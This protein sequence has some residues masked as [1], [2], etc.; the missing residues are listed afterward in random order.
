MGS[1]QA[2]KR[3]REII[4]LKKAA[5][6]FEEQ[7]LKVVAGGDPGRRGEL[8]CHFVIVVQYMVTAYAEGRQRCESNCWEFTGMVK[9]GHTLAL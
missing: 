4:F 8:Q 5:H 7:P 1:P 6:G 2:R 3:E 9:Y